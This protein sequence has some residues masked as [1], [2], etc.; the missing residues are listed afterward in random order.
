MHQIQLLSHEYCISSRIDIYTSEIPAIEWST[1]SDDVPFTRLGH[2]SLNSNEQSEWQSRELKS[3]FLDS[4]CRVLKLIFHSPYPNSLN[5]GNQVGLISVVCL[6][7]PVSSSPS[8]RLRSPLNRHKDDID[9]ETATLIRELEEKLNPLTDSKTAHRL[10][11]RIDMLYET[12]IQILSLQK[13]KN[14]AIRQEDYDTAKAIKEKI[15]ALRRNQLSNSVEKLGGFVNSLTSYL[16]TSRERNEDD[17]PNFGQTV[18]PPADL[19]PDPL[20]SYFSR[21][22]PQLIDSLGESVCEMVMSRD[23]RLREKGL[24]EAV[25]RMQNASTYGVN[26]LVRKLIGDKIVNVYIKSCELIGTAIDGGIEGLA[27]TFEFALV[28]L[29]ENRLSDSNK[30]V[31]DTAISTLV[32]IGKSGQVSNQLFGVYLLKPANSSKVITGRCLALVALINDLGLKGKK[33]LNL[34]AVVTALAEWF[35]ANPSLDIRTLICTV[36]GACIKSVG[37]GKVQ[38]VVDSLQPGIRDG[39]LYELDKISN[40]PSTHR[41]SVECEFCGR[42]DPDFMHEEKIDIHFWRDCPA[43]I[44]CTFCQQIVEITG[45]TEHRLKECTNPSAAVLL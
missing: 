21:D 35:H 10:K 37:I 34:E 1:N 7:S 15:D 41:S 26:W 30:R 29:S 45:L 19:Q 16:Q 17:L 28:H 5:V 27:E 8:H 44:E 2:L 12:G 40:G 6:G 39:L 9:L 43:L 33:G 13:E 42:S 14:E 20:P 36:L 11:A 25:S 22:Y 24:C 4:E 3:V 38:T 23:W 31:V 32:R 18:P